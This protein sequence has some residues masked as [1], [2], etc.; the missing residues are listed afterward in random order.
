MAVR[1]SVAVVAVVGLLTSCALVS[2][3]G[4][5]SVSDG[6]NDASP[7]VDA[8]DLDTTPSDAHGTGTALQ[9]RGSCAVAASAATLSGSDL[10]F[11]VAFWLRLDSIS[12]A[13]LE[14]PVVV[15]HGGRNASEPGWSVVMSASML[16]FCVSDA[17]TAKCAAPGYS[18]KQGHFVHVVATTNHDMQAAASRVLMLY[19]RD[20]TAGDTTHTMVGSVTGAANTWVS[21]S[22]LS[23]A[24]AS[25]GGNCS[26]A[27]SITIDDL[28][29]VSG[30]V[31]TSLM[32]SLET[33][34]LACNTASFLADFRFDEGMGTTAADCTSP[35]VSLA[36]GDKAS[37]IPS[38]F[39]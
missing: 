35:D 21:T 19:V 1:P 5:L 10:D 12:I 23:V 24:G 2:G 4:T 14:S 31:P 20:V 26:S 7:N 13:A 30:V 22:P 25:S 29:I 27:T 32:G 11:S 17:T 39:P 6:G 34:N 37:W 9:F 28:R 8:L 36:F 15:W 33:A 18:V 16:S 3:L 38:P